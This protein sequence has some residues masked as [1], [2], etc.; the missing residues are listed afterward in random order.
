MSKRRYEEP[1]PWVIASLSTEGA[2]I[3]LLW[4]FFQFIGWLFRLGYKLIRILISG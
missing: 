2:V 3:Y 1:P 4:S